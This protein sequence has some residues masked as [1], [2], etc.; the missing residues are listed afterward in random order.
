MAIGLATLEALDAQDQYNLTIIEPSFAIDSWYANDPGDANLHYETF[1]A[2][3]LEPWARAHL[4]TSGTEQNWLIGFSKSGIGGEDLI[5]KHPDL[6][7]L[8]A[9]WD[10]PADM[11]S[12]NQYG[13]SSAVAYGSQ[14]NFGANYQLSSAFLA[15]HRTSF[16]SQNRIWIGGYSLY[17][18]DVTDYNA[19]LT[20]QGIAH[21]IGPGQSMGH[22]WD[23]GSVP[24]AVAA[25]YQDSLDPALVDITPPTAPAF[26][27]DNPPTSITAGSAYSYAFSAEGEPAPTF[28]IEAG[29][30]PAGMSLNPTTGVLSGTPTV[31]GHFSFT[32]RAANGVAPAALT[33]PITI[34][35]IPAGLDHRALSPATS[36]VTA[37]RSQSY[38]AEGF[39]AYNNDLGDVTTQ[40][41]LSISSGGSCNNTSHSCGAIKAGS[42]T[43]TTTDATATGTANLTVIAA[44][45][46]HLVLSP[47]A[48]TTS[49]GAT[50][51][52]TAVGFDAFANSLGDVTAASTL[53]ITPTGAGTG[54]S[55]DN[56]THTCSAI[57]AGTYTVAGTSAGKTGT[58]SLT[59]APRFTLRPGLATAISVGRNGSVWVLGSSLVGGNYGIYHWNGNGWTQVPGGAAR[60]GV[61]PA[62]NPW[63]VN[64][65][66]HICHWNGKGWT[67]YP[68]A[69]TDIAV[70]ANG[71]LWV[72]GAS[73]VGGNYGIYHWNGNGW[74]QVPGGAVRIAVDP[75]ATRRSSTRPTTSTT[76]TAKAGPPTRAR[77]PIS[78]WGPTGRSGSSAP[79]R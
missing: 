17:G 46:D 62:G 31:A 4:A 57:Q 30:L 29:T 50:Q 20:S 64:S 13:S 11:S 49:G 66:H 39:D 14:A 2:S 79:T 47:V 44:R 28:A 54:A 70:G 23:A 42:Y 9:S 53:T 8:A 72:L 75:R 7:T 36:T 55:C 32:L 73:P 78:P 27:Q 58:A 77:R 65:A 56:T 76:G 15:A 51:R 6:F 38:V 59:V 19:L 63:I 74:T 71:S 69:A 48:S 35:V 1:M 52:Y 67:I 43:V 18:T 12:Y 68:G 16:V 22:R 24:A 26:D 40:A 34:T 41:S 33:S 3:D 21:T 60:I 5:L 37:G 45:L 25:L 10:F 61:D